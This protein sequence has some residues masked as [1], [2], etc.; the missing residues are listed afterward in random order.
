MAEGGLRLDPL[1]EAHR[2]A[3]RAACAEDREI[4]PIYAISYD[5]EHFDDSFAR[6]RSR[7]GGQAF[8]VLLDDELVGMSAYLGIEPERGV[9][10]IGNTYYIPRLRGTGLNR[11]VKDLMIGRAVA[12]GF[13]RIEFRVDARNARSQAAM[14]KLGAVREGCIRAERITWTGHVRDTI[15]FSILAGEWSE[16]G[17]S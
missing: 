15:L 12:C 5:P 11:R 9:L 13:R 10:E 6:L 14:A 17:G 4:W 1:A 3:L 7:A 2:E 16:A 8:A